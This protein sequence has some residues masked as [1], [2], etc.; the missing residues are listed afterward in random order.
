MHAWVSWFG[1]STTTKSELPFVLMM[2][3]LLF[4]SCHARVTDT[5]S[6]LIL[7]SCLPPQSIN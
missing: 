2:E 6:A 7:S 3:L 1:F 5:Y 4:A